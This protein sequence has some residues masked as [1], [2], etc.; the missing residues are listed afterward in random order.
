[1]RSTL[2]LFC[3][4]SITKKS[5][6]MSNRRWSSFLERHQHAAWQ[7]RAESIAHMIDEMS[8]SSSSSLSS[9][10]SGSLGSD[11][12]D[13]EMLV[14]EVFA[15][16]ANQSNIA[17]RLTQTIAHP[18][19]VWRTKNGLTI[20]ELSED[21]A[22]SFFRFRREHLQ[23][24]ADKLWPRLAPHLLGEKGRIKFGFGRY[25]CGYETLLLLMM[26]RLSRPCRI[27]R[28]M[29]AFFGFQRSKICAGIRG[30][31]NAMHTLSV[32]YLDPSFS[33]IGCLYMQTLSTKNADWSTTY[34]VSLTARC[35]KRVG[36]PIIKK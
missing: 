11:L 24:V 17:T 15:S 33:C 16:L 1:M 30:M 36:H 13:N 35:A 28:E 20:A 5:A 25:S 18:D 23:I 2:C 21:D 4:P 34:G 32:K 8:V 14:H 12:E 31:M 6:N 19:I 3:F 29:E 26:Y 27:Y 22:L 9:I 10:S 7:E